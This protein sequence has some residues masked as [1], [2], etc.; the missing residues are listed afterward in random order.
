MN[1]NQKQTLYGG[2]VLVVFGIMAL[3][4]I[5]WLLPTLLLA[6]GGAA[7]YITQRQ[8]GRVGEAVQGG[9]WGLGLALMLLT[10]FSWLPFLL[11]LGGLSLILRGRE[12]LADAAV[13]RLLA[14]LPL[15][16][17]SLHSGVPVVKKTSA[18]QPQVHNVTIVKDES[19][20][21]GETTRLR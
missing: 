6:G 8:I 7:I 19:A 11:L 9:L 18:V 5:W 12:P 2:I 21:T 15:R 13:Q 17:P 3:F 14:R 1:T 20:T 10:G 4:G 16:I